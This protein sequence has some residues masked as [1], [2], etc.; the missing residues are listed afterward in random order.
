MTVDRVP[1]KHQVHAKHTAEIVVSMKE[2]LQSLRAERDSTDLGSKRVQFNREIKAE[3]RAIRSEKAA[4]LAKKAQRIKRVQHVE[5]VKRNAEEAVEA[6]K[7]VDNDGKE[8]ANDGK[9]VAEDEAKEAAKSE[10][11]S[12]AR[13]E[14]EKADEKIEEEAKVV[15]AEDKEEDR[16]EPEKVAQLVKT[17]QRVK[18][19]WKKQ[20][21]QAK[22]DKN[23]KHKAEEAVDADKIEKQGV[24]KKQQMHAKHTAEVF[25]MEVKLQALRSERDQADFGPKRVE[26]AHEIK[27][28]HRAIKAAKHKAVLSATA[29]PTQRSQSMQRILSKLK[30]RKHKQPVMT[31][32]ATKQPKKQHVT[33]KEEMLQAALKKFKESKD[34]IRASVKLFEQQNQQ[35]LQEQKSKAEKQHEKNQEKLRHFSQAIRERVRHEQQKAHHAKSLVGNAGEVTSDAVV[36][37]QHEETA[38]ESKQQAINSETHPRMQSSIPRPTGIN[39]ETHPRMQSEDDMQPESSSSGDLVLSSTDGYEDDDFSGSYNDRG[40]DE[41]DND[42][43]TDYATD[44]IGEEEQEAHSPYLGNGEMDDVSRSLVASA[45]PGFW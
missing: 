26:L 34:D 5:E 12:Q 28:E 32:H 42:D 45:S 22:E 1:I 7:T 20:Q 29:A 23:V 9:E 27:A 4:Q 2:K 24:Q 21:V 36:P 30:H 13:Y 11:A 35:L 14:D 43:N 33:T 17:T 31:A 44:K 10:D 16:R 37:E 8:V 18:T 40:I 3:H 41:E 38:N 6:D 25:H 19:V 15:K 39:S